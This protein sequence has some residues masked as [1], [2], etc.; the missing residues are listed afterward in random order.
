MQRSPRLTNGA[1][2]VP[3]RPTVPVISRMR[4]IH[5]FS[6]RTP[7]SPGTSSLPLISEATGLGHQGTQQR[8]P[9]SHCPFGFDHE[10]L[11]AP[12]ATHIPRQLLLSALDLLLTSLASL[13]LPTGPSPTQYSACIARA[14]Q[15]HRDD[16]PGRYLHHLCTCLRV[17]HHPCSVGSLSPLPLLCNANAHPFS[18]HNQPSVPLPLPLRQGRPGQ[19]RVKLLVVKVAKELVELGPRLHFGH[20]AA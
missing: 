4:D 14:R 16:C 9:V 1:V 6:E 7:A 8:L 20:Q 12:Q 13:G 15:C 19:C 5:R 17:A 2:R 18:A 11:P 3:H 10:P